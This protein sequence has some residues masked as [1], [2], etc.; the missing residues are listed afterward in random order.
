[1][2]GSYLWDVSLAC[3]IFVFEVTTV[4]CNKTEGLL[5]HTVLIFLSFDIK[6]AFEGLRKLSLSL[7]SFREFYQCSV[8][9]EIIRLAKK[10]S[11]KIIFGRGFWESCCNVLRVF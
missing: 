6:N 7:I 9:F 5:M 3:A 11:S 4:E 8:I 10:K 1:M 2:R